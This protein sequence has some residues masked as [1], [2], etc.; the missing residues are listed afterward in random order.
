MK[1]KTSITLSEN[2]LKAVDKLRGDYGNRSQV[3]EEAVKEFVIHKTKAARDREDLELINKHADM[4]NEEAGD[5]L[6][7]QVNI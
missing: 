2:L 3:I 5:S 4:L 6:G 7:Y 1:R